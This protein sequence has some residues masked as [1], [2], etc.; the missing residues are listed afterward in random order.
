MGP[1]YRASRQT[2]SRCFMSIHSSSLR[3]DSSAALLSS[4][5]I[6]PASPPHALRTN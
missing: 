2:C 4:V 5:D 1:S 3:I 6:S